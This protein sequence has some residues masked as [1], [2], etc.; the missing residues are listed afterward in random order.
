VSICKERRGPYATMEGA[1]SDSVHGFGISS[2][3]LPNPKPLTLTKVQAQ[4]LAGVELYF[5]GQIMGWLPRFASA[6]LACLLAGCG[7]YVPEVQELYEP[8]DQQMFTENDLIN[9]IKCE[10]HRGLDLALA[11]Y[12]IPE[13]KG[14]Y[15]ADWFRQ[16]KATVN[17]KLTVEEKSSINPGLTWLKPLT[18]TNTFTLGAGLTGSSDASRIETIAFSYPLSALHAAG[19]INQ[20]CEDPNIALVMG[21]LK[22]GQFIEKKVGLST[23]PGTI[24][25]PYSAFNY[26]VS[27]VVVYSGSITPTWKLVDITA[28]PNSPFLSSSRSRTNDITIT[29]APPG[30]ASEAAAIHQ[31]TLIGQAVAAAIR[32]NGN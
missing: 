11:K 19:P 27:F 32:R 10:L 7:L 2:M 20:P 4:M 28:L 5:G 26:E 21:D 1:R 22:I 12:H 31:A 17:L 25:G 18:G 6:G 9:N 24:V 23:I 30:A 8:R 14:I 3:R 13:G 29:F 16:W 15:A